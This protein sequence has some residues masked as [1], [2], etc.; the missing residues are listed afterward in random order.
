V[1]ANDILFEMILDSFLND[2]VVVKVG[3]ITDEDV[4]AIVNAANSSLLGGSG[5]DGAI[6]RKAGPKLL[7]ECREIRRSTYPNGLPTGE[8][9]ATSAGE[10]EAR[11]VIHTVGPIYGENNGKDAQLL[12][13]CYKNS[14]Q[15][16]A[17]F[18]L[19]TVAFPAISTG[20]YGYPLEDAA[21]VSSEAI[22]GFLA[23][24]SSIS[25][26]RLVFFSRQAADVFIGNHAF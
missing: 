17:D 12:A 13:N 10:L 5:V 7:A 23:N 4:D 8:A 11:Y 14:L 22:R 21:E 9:V 16:A 2:R 24:P 18:E 25:E 20:V 1:H 26:I 6:H 3:D 15:L 19:N